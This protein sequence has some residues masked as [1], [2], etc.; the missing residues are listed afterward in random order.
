MLKEIPRSIRTTPFAWFDKQIFDLGLSLKAIAT[1]MLLVRY[2]DKDTQ[3][4]FPG[5]N[6]MS[7]R[8]G[9]SKTTLVQ[10]IKELEDVKAVSV[11]RSTGADGNQVNVYLL[12]DLQKTTLVQ[13]LDKGVV[14]NLDKGCSESGQPLVQNLDNNNNQF[15]QESF[16]NLLEGSSPPPPKE[17]LTKKQ[18]AELGIRNVLFPHYLEVCERAS[19]YT[20]LPARLKKG[21]DRFLECLE[22]T[23]GDW[24]KAGEMFRSAIDALSESDWHMGRDKNTAGKKWNDWIDN[25]CKSAEQFEKWLVKAEEN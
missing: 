13:N 9:C 16:N 24:N 10:A 6:G 7:E 22:K 3:K 20:L 21:A 19:S 25:L 1:Y 4:C 12:L 11:Q 2:S 8:L 14:Q 18:R 17:S 5:L 23:D 15:K